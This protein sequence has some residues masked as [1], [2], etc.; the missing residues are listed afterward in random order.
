VQ[1]DVFDMRKGGQIVQKSEF[2]TEAETPEPETVPG[3]TA[4]VTKK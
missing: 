4:S 1:V 2:F 3:S